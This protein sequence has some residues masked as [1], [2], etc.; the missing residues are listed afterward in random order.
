MATSAAPSHAGDHPSA[1]PWFLLVLLS[2][3]Y[4]CAT[5][6]RVVIGLLVEPIKANLKISDVQFG[7]LQGPA[8]SL[9]Y[10]VFGLPMGFLV[11]RLNRTRLVS[12][13][14]ACWSIVTA[15][16]GLAGSFLALFLAR[17]GVGLGEATLSP[18][19]YSLIGDSFASERHGVA[20]GIFAMSGV[21]GAGLSMVVGGFL[22][23]LIEA[24]GAI[25]APFLGTLQPWQQ[26]FLLLAL[27]GLLLSL[28]FLAVAEPRRRSAN[29]SAEAVP[30]N[31][32][33]IRAFYRANAAFLVR[34]HI[35]IGLANMIT[36]A[37]LAWI[38]ALY[39]RVHGWTIADIGLAS[40]IA[41][42]AG[43]VVGLWGGG[44]I[45]DYAMRFGPQARLV[46]CGIAVLLGGGAAA[47]YPL[48]E[49]ASL[50]MVGFWLVMTLSCLPMGAGNAALQYVVPGN[51][52]GVA[53]AVFF[54]SIGIVA[55]FGPP[56][57]ALVSESAFPG[58]TGLR[59][60]LAIVSPIALVGSSLFFFWA[61]PPYRRALAALR[62]TSSAH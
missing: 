17:T 20:L 38:A 36:L 29:Q 61:I 40:G 32:S 59:F 34:H 55:M 33:S 39:I 13:G 19:S 22:I 3:A 62:L 2:M 26:V 5:L 12:F 54:F 21:L 48:L 28:L 14:I 25:V 42:M 35:A 52:R 58:S 57:V 11:D 8:F 60:G 30:G 46:V 49:N 53:S 9:T 31:L 43:A 41:T 24:R 51:F 1:S 47:A 18:S 4:V 23:G 37:S 56:L 15:M 44:M 27:P 16:H 45:S 6:D 10:I 7:L 50:A